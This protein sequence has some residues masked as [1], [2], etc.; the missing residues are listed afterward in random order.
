LDAAQCRNHFRR[1]H[2][3][4]RRIEAAIPQLIFDFRF[5]IF[6]LDYTPI[7]NRKSN[8]II[9]IPSADRRIRHFYPWVYRANI[10]ATRGEPQAGDI[11]PVHDADGACVGQGFYN[12]HSHI[13][14]RMLSLSANPIDEKFFA[15]RL[16]QARVRRACIS[17]TNAWR[18]VN[19]E[20]D[21]LPGLI[22]DKL[23]DVLVMQVRNAGI[24]RRKNL[25]V[26]L[27]VD[28]L[29][30][31]GIYER[32]DVEA[33][34]DEGLEPCVGAVWGDV[35]TRVSVREDDL[36]F[37]ISLPAGQKT[38]FY[39]DQRDNR[40]RLRSMVREGDRV[41]DVYSYVGAFGLH[42]ARA[43]AQV[44]LVDKDATA[45]G[46]AE[47]AA[48]RH[49]LWERMGVRWGDALEVMPAFHHEGRTF[50]HIVLDPPT[51]VKRKE[52]VPRAKRLFVELCA[53]AMRLLHDNGILFLSS[54]AYYIT[55]N[56]LLDV[57]RHAADSAHRRVEVLDVT[58]QPADHPW[59]LQAPETLYLKTLILRVE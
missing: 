19:A 21:Q 27:L 23:D 10:Q 39:L 45:L 29:Q 37:E 2:G 14:V 46:V 7:K 22:V 42:A 4:P 11:V 20:S 56:D 59:I 25:I 40:R 51:L 28:L 38:G 48:R 55:I 58:Y 26:E 12:P 13:P 1:R 35:P 18:V 54:C 41:L 33:R 52:D 50:T 49:G 6:D 9:L 5:L 53:S 57:A 30:P 15:A 43:G 16:R 8:M 24:E 17:H 31:R 44:L 3:V 32:S 34:A 36:E 47:Q